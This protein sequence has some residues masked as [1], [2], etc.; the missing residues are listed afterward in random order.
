[1][2][3]KESFT[4]KGLEK[5]YGSVKNVIEVN[6]QDNKFMA[7]NSVKIGESILVTKGM[8]DSTKEKLGEVGLKVIE[9]DMTEI[10]KGGGS[11]KCLSMLIFD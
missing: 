4:A 3:S 8:S 7:C 10:M 9:L 1:M 6:D 5:I 11:I 2:I